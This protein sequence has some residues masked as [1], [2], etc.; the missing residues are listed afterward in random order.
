MSSP[1][2]NLYSIEKDTSRIILDS[3]G[4]INKRINDSFNSKEMKPKSKKS[5]RMTMV[6]CE[7][8]ERS[9]ETVHG[10]NIHMA[11][12]HHVDWV[13]RSVNLRK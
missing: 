13:N 2:L 12:K 8:C 5:D 4:E 3:N 9:F 7:F 1:N 11:R 6:Q 10:H